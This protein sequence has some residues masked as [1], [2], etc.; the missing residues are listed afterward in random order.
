MNLLKIGAIL[1]FIIATVL[2]VA[3]HPKLHNPMIIED[4]N[5]EL[6]EETSDN[7]PVVTEIN[8]TIVQTQEVQVV[9]QPQTKNI[10]QIV[11]EEPRT[12]TK[13][14]QVKNI[15]SQPKKIEV[16]TASNPVD[17]SQSELIR[18]VL[19]N[20]QNVNTTEQEPIKKE[21]KVEVP[22]QVKPQQ[23]V[24]I[25]Q[26]VKQQ[27]VVKVE[28]PVK[29]SSNPYMTEEE[30]II[31]WNVWRS[32]LH[33]QIMKDSNIAGSMYGT[34]FSF[35]FIVDKFGN[36]SNIKVTA[37]PSVYMDVARTGVKPAIANLQNKSILN[38]PRGTKRTSTVVTGKFMVSNVNKFSTPKE[39]SDYERVVR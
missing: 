33:N 20:V 36:I 32:N 27:Q 7:Q 1:L 18:K 17:K 21:I 13:T 2:T 6:V 14:V 12:Q 19:H 29:T 4:A 34:I 3:L 15:Q 28:Q 22:Q 31:A 24:K 23:Q 9:E 8:P 11:Y 35:S 38:F 30:E 39:Y 25:E 5:F 10:Q 16:Q 26:P 37:N